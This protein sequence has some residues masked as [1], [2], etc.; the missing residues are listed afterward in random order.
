LPCVCP[1]WIC[2]SAYMVAW[3]SRF[4]FA[5]LGGCFCFEKMAISFL[6]SNFPAMNVSWKLYV[7]RHF[8]LLFKKKREKKKF[9]FVLSFSHVVVILLF[10]KKKKRVFP[11]LSISCI[12]I[13]W[14]SFCLHEP[15]RSP[16]ASFHTSKTNSVFHVVAFSFFFERLHSLR[17]ANRNLIKRST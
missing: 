3:N 14:T 2:W 17:P 16:I 15:L 8:F 1:L 5:L 9:I 6:K 11:F 10:Q 4:S 12:R 13:I 7:H